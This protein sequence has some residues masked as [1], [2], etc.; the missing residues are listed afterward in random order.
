[1]SLFHCRSSLER[2][3]HRHRTKRGEQVK[4]A[5]KISGPKG[6]RR[7]PSFLGNFHQMRLQFSGFVSNFSL[8]V[9][10]DIT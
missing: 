1:E 2:T 6:A 10:F 7:A 9:T 8:I 4:D 5:E 3:L